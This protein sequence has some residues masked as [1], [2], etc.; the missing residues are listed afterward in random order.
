MSPTGNRPE[1]RPG[2]PKIAPRAV[3][4]LVDDQSMVAEAVRRM[5]AD[6]PDIAFHYCG[7]PRAAVRKAAEVDATVIIHDLRPD[8]DGMSLVKYFRAQPATQHVSIIVLSSNDDP[9]SK[10]QA[11]RDG[12]NDY[13]V[14]MPDTI[15]L[16]SRIMAHTRTYLARAANDDGIDQLR[17]RLNQQQQINTLL[18]RLSD[19]DEVTAVANRRSF[20]D[21]L[22]RE[23]RR[24]ARE[25]RELSVILIAIDGFDAYA[26]HGGEPAANECLA[27]VA[28]AIRQTLMR[29]GDVVGRYG[30][31]E[32]ATLMP[33]TGR[34]GAQAVATRIRA[35]VED[36][37][38][39]HEH[40]AGSDHVTV[41]VSVATCMPNHEASSQVL[42][43]AAEQALAR[44]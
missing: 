43:H 1:Q 10:A 33:G 26:K 41:T 34:G 28:Q 15:E 22:E 16:V 29:P 3:V 31:A 8:V 39:K 25:N 4:L 36:L 38:I 9:E 40:A 21:L 11:F 30:K 13:L 42:L 17:N 32:F 27:S 7:E 44:K 18:K 19:R 12:A 24:G 6:Q 2:A 35:A 14:K 23:W 5:L 37:D 20:L